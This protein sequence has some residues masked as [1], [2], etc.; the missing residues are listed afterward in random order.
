MC[1]QSFMFDRHALNLAIL[2]LAGVL[3]SIARAVQDTA[4]CWQ[5]S[6]QDGEHGKPYTHPIKRHHDA[7]GCC[8]C[9]CTQC[10]VLVM[11]GT[12]NGRLSPGVFE[13]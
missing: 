4:H 7:L 1:S 3:G 8:A 6:R 13:Q 9:V 10:S 5:R 11:V 2:V 12:G